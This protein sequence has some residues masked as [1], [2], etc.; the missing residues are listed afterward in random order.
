MADGGDDIFVYLGG[1]QALPF[2]VTHV[3][4][5]IDPSKLFPSGHSNL[6]ETCC[7]WRLMMT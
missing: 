2:D 1:E 6:V 3:F 5:S 4:A 7:L